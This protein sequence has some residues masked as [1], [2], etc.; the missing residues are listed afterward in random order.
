[1]PRRRSGRRRVTVEQPRGEAEVTAPAA[2]LHGPR[3]PAAA[4]QWHHL[5]AVRPALPPRPEDAAGFA[6]VLRRRDF[7]YLWLAQCSSQ[8]AQ[9]AVFIILMIVIFQASNRASISAV[10]SVAFTLPGVLLSAPAGVYADRHDKQR[11]MLL[12]NLGRAILLV[13]AGLSTLAPAF[14]GQ[15][16]PLLVITVAFSSAGQLFAPAEAASIPTLVSREQL[17]GATSLFMTT[18]IVSI[19]LGAAMGS[20]S[21]VFGDAI[22]FYIG[23][24]LFGLATLFV[25][26]ISASLHAVPSGTV[27]ETHVLEDLRDGLRILRRG[28]ALRWGMIQL[29]LALIVVFTVYALGPDYM[30]RLLGPRGDQQTWIVLVPATIGLMATAWV[31]GQHVNRL[32]RRTLMV[33]AFLQAGGCLLAMAIGP[34]LLV[35]A[36]LTDVML[37][38]VVILAVLF[39]L[40]LGAIVIPAFTIL[41]EGTTEESRGRIFGGVFTVVNVAIAIPALAAGTVAD[42]LSVFVAAG[43]VGALVIAVGLAF[44]FVLW[45]RLPVIESSAVNPVRG[46]RTG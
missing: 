38:V 30:D 16:W 14:R 43:A 36:G 39:G 41:Q 24:G 20:V 6:R 7:R 31:L 5:H 2:P 10:V 23:A 45:N 33:T 46:A 27:P 28:P 19:V 25:W 17:Q 15:A 12:T 11:L 37:A 26:R 35:R 8:L 29:G 1:M 32:S 13:V 3:S 9:N 4:E 40:A 21:V 44:R 42:W 34:P 22:P 18:V